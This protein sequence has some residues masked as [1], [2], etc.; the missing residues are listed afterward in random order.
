MALK[1]RAKLTILRGYRI[2]HL[3]RSAAHVYWKGV[4][5]LAEH[6]SASLN[7]L[8]RGDNAAIYRRTLLPSRPVRP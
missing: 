5:S 7:H 2:L 4:A 1:A 6:A 3:P 8:H